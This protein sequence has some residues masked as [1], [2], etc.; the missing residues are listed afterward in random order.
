MIESVR[1]S[2]QALAAYGAL[3]LLFA[4]A[5]HLR[6]LTALD[7]GSQGAGIG[8][9]LLI[10]P[11]V[12]ALW[13]LLALRWRRTRHV[14]T[15]LGGQDAPVSPRRLRAAHAFSWQALAVLSPLTVAAILWWRPLDPNDGSPSE[16]LTRAAPTTDSPDAAS[17]SQPLGTG[18]GRAH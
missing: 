11:G 4:V 12:V 15:V 5:F 3:G 17:P 9:R 8:F 7:L 2:L 13:P 6:G 14:G 10:T 1:T 18:T 16:W